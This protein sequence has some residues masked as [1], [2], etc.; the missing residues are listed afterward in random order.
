MSLT[1]KLLG[2]VHTVYVP[3]TP[4]LQNLTDSISSDVLGDEELMR[5]TQYRSGTN[6]LG[7]VFFCLVFGTFLGTLGEKGQIVIDFFKAV[8]EVI[9]RMVSTVMWYVQRLV[10][11]VQVS[12]CPYFTYITNP[13]FNNDFCISTN[14][15]AETIEIRF[16]RSLIK[17]TN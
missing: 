4:P 17:F 11:E 5:V 10:F 7:I 6:T 8:F 13:D 12:K 9:M 2:Q 1:R 15:R 3:K 16:K 14:V